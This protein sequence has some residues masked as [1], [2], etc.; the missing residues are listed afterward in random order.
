MRCE[1]SSVCVAL[2][3]GASVLL[4][5]NGSYAEK[6]RAPTP[7]SSWQKGN[8]LAPT[9]DET[10]RPCAGTKIELEAGSTLDVQTRVPL[11]TS[12]EGLSPHA[13]AAQL[14]AGRVD[15]SVDPKQKQASGVLIH[16]PRRTTILARGG[17][18]SVIAKDGSVAVGVYS[19]R[20]ASIGIGSTWRHVAAGHMLVVSQAAPQGVESKLPEPPTKVSVARPAL[21]IPG[22]T[23]A[24]RAIWTPVVEAKS[25]LVNLVNVETK[26]QKN[27]ETLQ[28]HLALIGLSAGRYEMRV[29]AVEATGL[30]ST[31]SSPTFVNV[32]GVELPP[33]AFVSEGR[34]FLEALQQVTLTHVDGLEATY[35]SAPIYFKAVSRVGLRGTQATTLHLRL[36]GAKE[37]SSLELVPRA[38]HTQVDIIPALARW[39]RDKVTVRIKL[40]RLLTEGTAAIEVVPSITVNNQTVHLEWVQTDQGLETVIRS[41]PVYPGPWVLRA[42]VTDQHGIVLGR[43]FLEIASTAGLDDEE[44]PREIHRGTTPAQAKR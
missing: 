29:V 16:G 41:P 43:N 28:S 21:S 32:V 35:D 9:H 3:L 17:D 27:F 42:E 15:I 34:V 5:S 18:V 24:L 14:S 39:P 26:S 36:P 38:L 25:Y 22:S 30:R 4:G 37:R 31:E 6:S 11:P 12:I 20:E 19:G 33:G 7:A 13:Y 1:P 10:Y 23:D 8:R 44:V 2:L 40:P